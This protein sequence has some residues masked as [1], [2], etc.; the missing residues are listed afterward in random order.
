MKK[1]TVSFQGEY[2]AFSEKAAL[3]YFGSNCT[4]VPRQNFRDVFDDVQKRRSLFGVIPIENSVF[5]SIAQNYDLL[6]E[7]PLSVVGELKLRIHHCL[8][9]MPG[10]SIAGV[11]HIYSHPQ[12]LGQCE[13]FLQ[14]M[15]QSTIHQYYDTAGAAKMIAEE[16]RSDAAAIASEQAAR[17]YGLKIIRKNIETDHRNFTRF[18]ILSKKPTGIIRHGKTSIIFATKHQPGSL[19][20][21]LSAFADRKINLLKIESRPLIGKPWEYIFFVDVDSDKRNKEFLKALREL[22]DHATFV[23]ILGS[24]K[25]GKVIQ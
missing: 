15:K 7:Y 12:A 8:M 14:T 4:P 11:R 23:K 19:V 17:H 20:H 10:T 16:R 9:A 5:G 25:F 6:L 21:C 1:I 18:L 2:G 22:S 24:Y 3:S 13:V